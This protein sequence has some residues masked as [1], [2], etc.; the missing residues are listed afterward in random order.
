[1]SCIAYGQ[2]HIMKLLGCNMEYIHKMNDRGCFWKSRKEN[3]IGE[4]NMRE[5]NLKWSTSRFYALLV[6]AQSYGMWH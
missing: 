1:M 5:C 3:E 2:T 4:G 6:L